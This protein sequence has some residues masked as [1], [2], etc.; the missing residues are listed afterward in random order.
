[1]EIAAAFHRVV[2]VDESSQPSAA[3]FLT[4]EL[5]DQVGLGEEDGYRAGL[6]ATELGTNLVKHAKNGE[7]LVR[8]VSGSPRGELEVIAIDRGPGMA[9]IARSMAD[10][11]STTGSS[12]TGLGAIRRLADEFDIYSQPKRGSVV[13]VRLRD[14]RVPPANGHPFQVGGVSVPKSGE[15]V[16][17]DGWTVRHDV[18]GL[19]ALLVDGLGHGIQAADAAG[20]AMT[21]FARQRFADT[22]HALQ[23]LHDGLRHTRGAAGAVLGISQEQ[24]ILRF[25]GVGNVS[26]AIVGKDSTRQ[27]VSNNGTLGHQ[28]RHFREYTYPWSDDACFVMHSDGLT[29][30]WSLDTYHGLCLRHPAVVAAVLYR[31]F[32]RNRD[33]VTVLVG[34]HA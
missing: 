19:S 30:H 8:P 22:S 9:D 25:S 10:G 29:S 27:A 21:T 5:A 12:G 24:R 33:D 15:D 1:M 13:Y 3:R 26:C 16:C 18:D 31:D 6:V 32:T 11:H 2:A 7:I 20:A 28:A 34:R 23:A 14:R 17:G 4:R